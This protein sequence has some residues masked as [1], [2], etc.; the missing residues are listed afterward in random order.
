MSENLDQLEA[1]A[2]AIDA[3]AEAGPE[4]IPGAEVPPPPDV[5]AE[6]SALLLAV[7]GILTPAFPSLARIYDEPTCKRLG[8]A[9]APVLEKYGV[10][11]GGLFDRFGA[12]ISLI[13]TAFPVAVATVQ[14]VKSDLAARRQAAPP[15]RVP[16]P[17]DFVPPHA[18]AYAQERAGGDGQQ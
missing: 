9:T 1:A 11:V 12:E 15:E 13:A 5:A 7:A 16:H 10:S 18:G 6:V 17:G 8:A 4:V 14:G 3:A 2:A